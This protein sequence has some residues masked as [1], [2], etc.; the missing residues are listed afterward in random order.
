MNYEKAFYILVGVAVGA[1]GACFLKSG[2]GRKTAVALASKGLELKERV[3]SAA[4]RAKETA[5]DI[6][7]EARF[8][9]EKKAKEN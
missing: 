1:A 4:E 2:A 5:S 7:A 8:A 9:N 3:A 6:V